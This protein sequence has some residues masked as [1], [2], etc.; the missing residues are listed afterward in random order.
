[1]A[2]TI[3]QPLIFL[4]SALRAH[5]IALQHFYRTQSSR[6]WLVSA[7]GFAALVVLSATVTFG[8]FSYHQVVVPV[9]E[10][11]SPLLVSPTPE[12]SPD[13]LKPYT[14]LLLGYGGG[15]HSGGRLTDTIILAQVRPAEKIVR[16]LSIPR[17][18]WVEL[19][20]Q[21]NP[22]TTE[23][24]K[25]GYKINAA[26]AIGS[27][28][29]RYTSKPA[30][31]SG[32]SGGGNLAKYGV[33]IISGIP[34]DFFAAV[35]FYGFE[36]GIDQLGGIWVDVPVAFTD[37][38][39]PLTGEEDNPCGLSEEAIAAVTATLSGFILEKEFPCRYESLSF[40]AGKQLLDGTTALKLARSRHSAVGGTDFGRLQRQ[41]AVLRAVRDR[42][43]SLNALPDLLKLLSRLP[44]DV[45]T[46]ISPTLI[47][48][49][50]SSHGDL[51]E[52]KIE[53]LSLT[54]DNAFGVSRS[55]D[56]QFI[57]IPKAGYEQ[58]DAVHVLIQHFFE[59]GKTELEATSPAQLVTP[60]PAAT[61]FP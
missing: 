61:P 35:S 19:P 54:D 48:E 25:L 13:P 38:F 5:K 30:E 41:Q 22:T 44:G 29:R 59:T 43:L 52:F 50:M 16:L 12:P 4:R 2:K 49:K 10:R 34:V 23:T 46:D 11:S 3:S 7:V 51:N 17:D 45:Q 57:L 37:P 36:R 42:V 31:F 33:E 6:F 39:Y 32:S 55:R 8:F 47:S 40:A 56:G 60:S 21:L 20:I 15:A 26:Y 14:V 18:A 53:A 1:M 24:T 28:D 9:T 27:D 58:W